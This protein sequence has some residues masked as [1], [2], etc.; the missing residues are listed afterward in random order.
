MKLAADT[1]RICAA[2]PQHHVNAGLSND[3]KYK[4]I[5]ACATT[6][7]SNVVASAN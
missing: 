7:N 1:M 4:V 3:L 6:T 5:D 2:T